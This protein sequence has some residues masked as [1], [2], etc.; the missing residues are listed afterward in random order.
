MLTTG[1]GPWLSG[2]EPRPFARLR[3]FCFPFAGGSASTYRGWSSGLPPEV[4]VCPIQLPGREGRFSEPAFR[5]IP[6]LVPVLAD[7]L[8]PMFDKPFAFYGHSLGSLI[9]FELAHE[10][11]ARGERL[12]AALFPAAHQAPKY[13]HGPP[14]SMFSESDLVAHI[15]TMNPNA[16]LSEN[17]TFLKL[18]LPVLRIDLSLCDYYVYRQRPKLSCTITTFGGAKDEGIGQE[19]LAAWG[20][21]TDGP[22]ATEMLSGGHFFLSVERERLLGLLSRYCGQLMT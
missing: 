22:F 18:I 13:P 5:S 14:V 15:E 10:L 6:E 8:L 1:A 3:L 4:E 11:R 17:P 9:A 7:V 21:E 12:P 19:A 2:Y 16:K 20:E